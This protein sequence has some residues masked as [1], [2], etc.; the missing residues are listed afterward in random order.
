MKDQYA[1]DVNDF[2]KYALLRRLSR[3]L[4][5]TVCWMRTP[6]DQRSDG[7]RIA[8]L[9]RPEVWREFDAPLFDGLRHLVRRGRRSVCAIERAR[10]LEGARF[11]SALLPTALAERARYFARLEARAAGSDLLFFDPDNG[12]EIRSCPRGRRGSERYLYWD[13]LARAYGRGCSVLV[14]QHFPRVDRRAYVR[15]MDG[16]IRDRVG[17]PRV[18]ALATARV[19]FFLIPQR[20]HLRACGRRALAFAR[21]WRDGVYCSVVAPRVAVESGAPAVESAAALVAEVE[22]DG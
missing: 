11:H 18:F 22:S 15:R 1:G 13:E 4:T 6:D 14:Y 12:L 3:D 17:A 9:A 16:E 2:C 20:R 10:I 19:V 7:A 21:E 8:Y 5:L